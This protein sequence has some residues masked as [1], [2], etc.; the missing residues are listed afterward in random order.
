MDFGFSPRARELR[1]RMRSFMEAHVHPGEA[2][3]DRQ[4]AE[5]GN[6]HA[7]PP[8][9]V[10]LKEKARAEGLWNLFMS[11]GDW[12]AGLTNLEYAPLA[13]MAGRSSSG[14]RCSTARLRTPATWNCS[15]CTARP[16]SRTAGCA[17][18]GRPRSARASR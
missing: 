13:E 7:L 6:P 5:A 15:P 10:E 17:A 16:S 8:V 1:D 12:G 11:H 9:M 4:L 14:P 2:V 3:Y 18:A